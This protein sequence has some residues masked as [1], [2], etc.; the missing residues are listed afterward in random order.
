MLIVFVAISAVQGL[1]NHKTGRAFTLA[2]TLGIKTYNAGWAEALAKGGGAYT[3]RR[4]GGLTYNF[5]AVAGTVE[6]S[7]RPFL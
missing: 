7:F 5:R 1:T 2:L 4:A 6:R 3:L